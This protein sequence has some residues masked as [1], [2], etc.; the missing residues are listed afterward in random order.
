MP[1]FWLRVAVALYGA[2]LGY[3][4]FALWRRREALSRGIVPVLA[5]GLVLHAVALIE[6]LVLNGRSSIFT[7][8][9]SESLLGLLLMALFLI[10]YL[11][12]RTT[13]PGLFVI[14]A[15]F[16]LTLSAALAQAPPHFTS[17]FARN[18]WIIAHVALIFTGYAALFLSF[19]SSVLYL[20]QERALKSKRLSG[21]LSRLPSLQMIDD[22]GYRTL[23]LGF[24]FITV[25]LIMGS[26]LA[27]SIFGASYF[28][29]P[30]VLLSIIMWCLYVGL[31]YSRWSS[32]WRGKRAAYFATFAFAAAICA[33]AANLVS[34]VHRYIAP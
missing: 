24:P 4:L 2:G 1:L 6:V 34:G 22:M 23:L 20:W 15:V 25:G 9:Q 30:K 26:V 5:L 21:V 27:E 12:Y 18:G 13:S 11:R 31:L 29:D 7:I 33:W 14:P 19:V 10:T 32:G 3:A 8:H 28:R 17:P 16:L